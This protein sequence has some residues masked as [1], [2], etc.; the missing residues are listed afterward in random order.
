VNFLAVQRALLRRGDFRAVIRTNSEMM[1]ARTR[2]RR[3]LDSGY[4]RVLSVAELKA[5]KT[6]SRAFVFG[7]GSS[8]NDISVQEW[9]EI[10]RDNTIGFNAF[11]SQRWVRIDFQLVRSWREG[12]N[13]DRIPACVDEF[14]AMTMSN[15]RCDNAVIIYQDDYSSMFAHSLLARRA[16]REHTRVFPYHT[17]T[18]SALPGLTF[19]DGLTH[20]MATLCDAVNLGVCLEYKEIV[21]TGVDLYDSRY[22]WLPRDKTYAL[23]FETAREVV[24]DTATRGQRFDE[25]HNTATNGVVALLGTWCQYLGDRGIRLFVHNPRSLL[26][27]VMPVYRDRAAQGASRAI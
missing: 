2:C 27:Q 11:A 18:S 16:L 13:Y 12:T 8:L 15:P 22:F 19:A 23:D 17:R 21:L 6:S 3:V 9:A 24:Q 20:A 25:Q 5:L 14:A 10:A 7:S 26:A 4:Y 1:H